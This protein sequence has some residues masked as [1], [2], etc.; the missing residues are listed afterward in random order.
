VR[1]DPPARR[2]PNPS[3][4]RGRPPRARRSPRLSRVAGNTSTAAISRGLPSDRDVN[5]CSANRRDASRS[6]SDAHHGRD[7][8]VEPCGGAREVADSVEERATAMLPRVM[9]RR[10][11][12]RTTAK[13][14][15]VASR[16]MPR[17]LDQAIL[18][19]TAP[20]IPKKARKRRRLPF[21]KS[22]SRRSK[23]GA[24]RGGS[25]LAPA[26]SGA[27]ALR[28]RHFGVPPPAECTGSRHQR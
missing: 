9:P 19:P 25:S 7:S 11:A 12:E 6:A 10:S 5:A 3:A 8:C 17:S 15:S 23:L 1:S 26:R 27:P 28:L 18:E 14:Y 16:T 20:E 24:W 2:R 21:Q 22:P 4:A 13:P